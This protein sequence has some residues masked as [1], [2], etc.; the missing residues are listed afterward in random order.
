M[1]QVAEK[2]GIHACD[3][4]LDLV[5]AHGSKFRWKTLIANHRPKVLRSMLVQP[6]V[7][8]GFADS[9]AHLRNM[10]FY[11]FPLHLLRMA[12][13]AEETKED[14][15][16]IEEAVHRLSGEPATWFDLDAGRLEVGSRA[17]IA[18]IH[19]KGLDKSLDEFYEAPMPKMGIKRMVRRND[20]AVRATII[21]GELAFEEGRFSDDFGRK[22]YGR[23]LRAGV[24]DRQPIESSSYAA[25]SLGQTA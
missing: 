15:M 12:R 14:F 19:P 17:D 6:T 10:A 21:G 4:F 23:F 20:E 22:R 7:Q 2:R 24:E 8:V 3:A 9:G 13:E 5:V 16:S 18:V 25:D 1:A 11:N